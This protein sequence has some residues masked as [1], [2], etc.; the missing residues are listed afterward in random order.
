MGPPTVAEPGPRDVNDGEQMDVDTQSPPR[1]PLSADAGHASSQ[2]GA[3]SSTHANSNATP[4]SPRGGSTIPD[5][6]RVS[7][8]DD[9]SQRYWKQIMGWC[10]DETRL[11][12]STTSKRGVFAIGNV[13]V[14]SDHLAG[15]ATG[16][17]GAMDANECA[18]VELLSDVLVGIRLP[19]CYLRRKLHGRDIFIQSRVPGTTLADAWPQLTRGQKINYK[20]Q[21]RDIIRRMHRVKSN[22]SGPSYFAETD[23][24]R[25]THKLSQKE[26]D[27]LYGDTSHKE[28][29]LT[30]MHNNMVRSN[31]LVETDRIVGLIGWSNAGYFGWDRAKAV[32]AAL[33]SPP[34]R[35]NEGSE[36]D[37]PWDDLY[38]VSAEVSEHLLDHNA[39]PDASVDIK[40]EAQNEGLEDVPYATTTTAAD[41]LKDEL[42]T[43]KKVTDLK[44][45]ST[46]RAP[47]SERSS[48]SPSAQGSNKRAAP[49]TTAT[50]KG[51]AKSKAGP[52]KRKLND[53]GD[54]N[55][56]SASR[57]SSATPAA[58]SRKGKGSTGKPQKRSSLS[59]ANSPAPD[60][61]VPDG[62]NEGGDDDDDDDIDVSEVFCICRKPDNHTWM[63]GCD[64]GCEDW[65]HGKCV[66]I[67]QVDADLIDKYICELPLPLLQGSFT[68]CCIL[69]RVNLYPSNRMNVGPS[70]ER[71]HGT[72]TTWKPM[73]RLPECRQPAR[74]DRKHPSKYCSDDHGRE[75]MRCHLNLTHLDLSTRDSQTNSHG[76]LEAA[77]NARSRASSHGI[78][79][80][81]HRGS[82]LDGG[83]EDGSNYD[84]EDDDDEIDVDDADGL[85]GDA[86]ISESRGGVLT[87]NDLKAAVSLTKSADE[88]RN[89]GSSVLLLQP[90]E[91]KARFGGGDS[92]A[93]DDIDIESPDTE[94]TSEERQQIQT[95]REERA[96]LRNHTN[97]LR[98][99]D[100]F[101]GLVRQQAK[102]ILDRLRQ[103]DPKGVAAWKD[104]CG[105]DPRLSWSDEEFDQWRK[106]DAGKKALAGDLEPPA[107]SNA[108]VDGGADTEMV[109]AKEDNATK[110]ACGVCIKKRCEQHKQWLR[111]QQ[112]D[113]LFEQATV[114]EQLEKCETNSKDVIERVVMRIY[115]GDN[116]ISVNG[117]V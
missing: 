8:D 78:G 15:E 49:A 115:G 2:P 91:I 11:N 59:I 87:N 39:Q 111:V 12:S 20:E 68:S 52:K 66:K 107:N 114:K 51:G 37:V 3:P 42:P 89:L 53:A 48:P 75:F 58:A 57:R 101:I 83:E 1:N 117:G 35:P 24:P 90:P 74:V 100:K 69:V 34:S 72:R 98:D 61:N 76:A 18:A 77:A 70:C 33:R 116:E 41:T 95:L 19:K 17:Y 32:H 40:K 65:F 104:I 26:Y 97:M 13:V 21:A 82:H 16:D 103:A 22:R 112:Q 73:C 64:G 62:A 10:N 50:K 6:S 38:D 31:I 47:S 81:R 54:A 94:L 60:E 106:A 93:I 108:G 109:D 63:I 45:E 67:D 55:A 25:V 30:A 88:F 92:N 14:K 86:N 28:N 9:E 105:F 56:S 43:P 23:N 99:R 96:R 29:D 4:T 46:S 44:R 79:K 110:I 7:L 113:I 5:I 102:H 84:D 36:A 80:S 71:K 85:H 27:I